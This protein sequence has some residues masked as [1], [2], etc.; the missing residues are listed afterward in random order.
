[1]NSS[2]DLLKSLKIDRSAPPPASHKGLWIG[3]GVAAVVVLFIGARRS[4]TTWWAVGI[5]FIL[6]GAIG[7]VLDRLLARCPV[8][9]LQARGGC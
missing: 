6:G 3:L 7:N 1:M 8:T 9:G 4:R 5:G 2:A